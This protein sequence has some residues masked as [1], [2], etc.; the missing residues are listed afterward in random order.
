MALGGATLNVLKAIAE[1]SSLQNFNFLKILVI[2]S[3]GDSKRVPQYSCCGK[4]F[5]PVQRE[6]PDGRSSSLFDEFIIAF[7]AVP[8]RMSP[9]MLVLSGDVLMVFNPL[10][11]DLQYLDSAAISIKSP[12]QTG[13]HH[14]VFLTD[15]K[16]EVKKFLHKQ[17]VDKLNNIGAVNKKGYVDIDTGAIYFNYTILNDL[18]SLISDNN[19]LNIIKFNKFVNEQARISFYGDFLYPISKDGTLDSYLKE[20]PENV[21]CDNLLECRKL[22]WDKLHKYTM[23]VIK[24]SPAEFIHFGTTHE[25]FDLLVKNLEN[26]KYLNWNRNVLSNVDDNINYVVNHSFIDDTAIIDDNVYIENSY[27]GKN[28][29]IGKNVILSNVNIE[30]ISIPDDIC[31]NTIITQDN[32]YVTRIYSILDNPKTVKSTE[33]LFLNCILENMMDK[34]NITDNDIWADNDKSIWKANLYTLENNNI[35][36]INSALTLYKIIN[37]ECDTQTVKKYFNKNRTSLSGSFNSSDTLKQKTEN[38]NIE[39]TLRSYQFINTIKRL[40]DINISTNI[41]LKSV[42]LKKQINNLLNIAEQYNYSIKSRI[43]LA[44]SKILQDRNIPELSSSK[45]EDKCYEEIKKVIRTSD[46]TVIDKNKIKQTSVVELPIRINF[47]GGWSDTP[48]Y[49]NENGGTVLNGAFTLNGEKPI[50]V[51]VEKNTDNKIYLKSID[52]NVET[53]INDISELQKCNNT[54]DMFSLVK[55]SLQIV[56]IVKT[57]DKNISDVLQRLGSGINITTD[58]ASIP[59]GSG[60]GTSSILAG[61]CLKALYN[62]INVP[63]SD[64]KLSYLTLEQEQLMETGGGWQD[65]IGGII[66]GIKCTYTNPGEEQKFDIQ[67]IKLSTKFKDEI[68][69]RLVLIY[70][71]QRRLAK[72]L[73]RDVMNSY[74]SYNKNTLD[75]IAELKNKAIQMRADLENEDLNT[76]SNHLNEHWELSKKLDAGCTNTCIDQILISCEDLI[77]GKMICGAGG[78]GF[79]QVILKKGVSKDEIKNRIQDVF[80]DSGI[81][82]YDV[83][84]CE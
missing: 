32:K 58:V 18:Y 24:L 80:Q 65:Q 55:A 15:E 35:D 42:D 57:T 79:L 2:H 14:G 21:I 75:V 26:Y 29:T 62:F 40:K 81:K 67:K 22:I 34:Y 54:N 76:F 53:T 46:P 77:L 3:G 25:L 12:V 36:S 56:G 37:C 59:K 17:S 64:E 60:L 49:C 31:L 72:N 28:V 63:I 41:L 47:A 16:N 39:I 27:I 1:D 69:N 38:E 83:T 73:L 8:A 5:S 11:I 68:N 6:L 44:I 30:N 48:P 82:V 61:A 45:F 71:G 9:G 66:P 78:G 43:Y 4:L 7:S 51:T 33:T 50:R 52:L 23:K 70:T 20:S 74:I 84:I 13:C 10:Q 19:T